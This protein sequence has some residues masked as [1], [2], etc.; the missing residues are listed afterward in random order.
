MT[1]FSDGLIMVVRSS[2]TTY[3]NLERSFKTLDQSKLLG[4]VLNDVQAHMFN[5]EYDYRYYQYGNQNVYPY[6]KSK[7]KTPRRTYFE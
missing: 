5:T 1:D 3:R 7:A 6:G 2:R 4:I